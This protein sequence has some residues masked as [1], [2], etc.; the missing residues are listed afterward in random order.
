MLLYDYYPSTERLQR[1]FARLN[2]NSIVR[3]YGQKLRYPEIGA[4]LSHGMIQEN[5]PEKYR[6]D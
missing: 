2:N 5:T 6:Y 1:S 3:T 4:M